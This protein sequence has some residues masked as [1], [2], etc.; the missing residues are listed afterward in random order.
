M[1]HFISDR[2][3]ILGLI[4][5]GVLLIFFAAINYLRE[6]PSL[7]V[8]SS[9]PEKI[10]PA[11]DQDI[12]IS[13]MQRLQKNPTDVDA[14]LHLAEYFMH[15]EDWKKAET[16]ARRAVV[17]APS[18]SRPFYMLGVIQHKQNHQTEAAESF[19]QALAIKEDPAIRY[20]LGLLYAWYLDKKQEGLKELQK[21]LNNSSASQELKDAAQKEIE[22]IQGKS[23]K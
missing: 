3:P 14:I 23:K 21:I 13:M 15:Q 5:L 6:H 10:T 7:T 17:T 1:S 20:S 16:F 8:H 11:P 18:E 22:K 19:T 4:I 2:R 9:T 12:V